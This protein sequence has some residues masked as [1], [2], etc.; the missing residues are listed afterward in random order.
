MDSRNT[1]VYLDDDED[2][3]EFLQ[4]AFST[5]L[6]HRLVSFSEATCLYDFLSLHTDV[7]CLVLLD[8]NLPVI[9][10]MDVLQYIRHSPHYH[11]LPVVMF[12]TGA[13]SPQAKQ[14]KEMD[15]EVIEK[16][17]TFHNM[18]SVVAH[19]LQYCLPAAERR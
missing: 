18:E 16:P 17:S 15:V 8:I 1:V 13:N 6:D 14:L 4:E 7:V 19:L 11:F 2:D 5:L 3:R 9:D 10:G 12:T